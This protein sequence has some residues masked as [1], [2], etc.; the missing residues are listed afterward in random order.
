MKRKLIALFVITTFM[1]GVAWSQVSFG[2]RAG[3]NFQN[4]NGEDD[5]GDKLDNDLK[6]GFHAGVEVDIPLVP[7]FYVQPGVL[8]NMKG[9]NNLAQVDDLS[10]SLGYIEV[11]IHFVFKPQ[12]GSGK[13]I[14]G[15]GPYLAY[16]ITGKMKLDNEEEDI[17][18]KN[19][20]SQ[21]DLT[22]N[23]FFLR[24]LDVGA[25]I[26][27][28]Y[29]FDFGFFA[30]LNAQLGLLNLEPKYEGEE[31]DAIT[32]NTGFGVSLGYKF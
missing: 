5:E 21:D 4:I 19:D 22:E 28:G 31:I 1:T 17:K 16:G 8:F 10:A 7:D 14:L 32:K 9:A 23:F 13:L 18:F 12:L 26:F 27:F 6:V 3:V 24:P 15:L 2:I 25:D 20:V 30:Q 11:P 29:Q